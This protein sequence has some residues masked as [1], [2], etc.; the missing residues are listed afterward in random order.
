MRRTKSTAR[1]SRMVAT[2]SSNSENDTSLGA[3]Q[4]QTPTPPAL[5]T[6][7][8][9]SNASSQRKGDMPSQRNQFTYK[10]ET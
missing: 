5:S 7:V 6:D 2:S 4:E 10:Y 1:Q 3:S 8:V 9:F